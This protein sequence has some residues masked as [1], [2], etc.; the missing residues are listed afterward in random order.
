[1]ARPLVVFV[2]KHPGPREIIE[3]WEAGL[4]PFWPSCKGCSDE[5]L[6][7]EVRIIVA[8]SH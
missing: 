6:Y 7:L 1:M 8:F 4:A 3:L 2:A 5:I